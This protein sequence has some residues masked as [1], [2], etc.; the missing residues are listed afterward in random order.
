MLLRLKKGF[1]NYS[2]KSAYRAWCMFKQRQCWRSMTSGLTVCSYVHLYGKQ[3]DL[4][5]NGINSTYLNW[6]TRRL[7]F[8]LYVQPEALCHSLS[9]ARLFRCHAFFQFEISHSC[10]W[11]YVMH[12]DGVINVIKNLAVINRLKHSSSCTTCCNTENIC[13][14]CTDCVCVFHVVLTVNID[15]FP[16]SISQLEWRGSLFVHILHINY[17]NIRLSVAVLYS[18]TDGGNTGTLGVMRYSI[19]NWRYYLIHADDWGTLKR[20]LSYL[21]SGIDYR[22]AG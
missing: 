13:F 1:K 19:H 10:C 16:N 2:W 15:Y 3:L 14:L 9:L 4:Q 6:R 8:H 11:S 17:T 18:C 22:C 12:T 20:R 7:T 5:V 21:D